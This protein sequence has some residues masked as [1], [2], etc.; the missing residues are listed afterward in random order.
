MVLQVM[1]A[2]SQINT[3]PA[4][5]DQSSIQG[6]KVP[7]TGQAGFTSLSPESLGILLTNALQ[8]SRSFTNQ[9]YLNGSG[10]AVGDV[11]GDGWC[12]LYFCGLDR[13]NALYRNLGNWR[14]EDIT[15]AAGVRG[16]GL[17]STGAVLADIDGDGD[18]DLLV[19]TVGHGTHCFLNDGRGHFQDVTDRIGLGGGAG[20]TSLALA[21]VD[22]DGYLDLFVANYR[23]DTLRDQPNTRFRIK[24]IDGQLTVALVNGRPVSE[25]DLEGRYTVQ[26]EGGIQE[27]GEVSALYLNRSGTHF[28][29]LPFTGGAFSDE[30][31]KPLATAPHDWSLSVLLRDLNGDGL[32]DIYVCND[33]ESP[34]RIWLNRGHGR[35]QAIPRTAI[36]HTS[37]YSMGV[38]V[39]D[40]NR[41]GFDDIFVVD[42]LSRWHDRRIQQSGDPVA[43]R[44][45]ADQVDG[46]P[47]Y[48]MNTLFLNR[49]NGTY[50]EIAGFSGVAASEW[51]WNPTF[52]DV[53]LDGYEDILIT[54]GHERD[55]QNVDV[56]MRVEAVRR[57]G[58][59]TPREILEA[60]R[61]FSRLATANVA[62]R[63][64]GD[65]TFEEVGKAWGFDLVGVSQGMAV[66]DLDND[67][68]LDV[69]I[70]NLNGT[71]TILRNETAAPRL[72]VQLRGRSPN[73]RGIGAKIHVSGGPVTQSQEMISGGRYLSGDQELRVFAAGSREA[74]LTVE[75]DWRSG[76]K[77]RL[78]NV[79]ANSL[80]TVVEP[81]DEATAVTGTNR[82]VPLFSDRSALLNHV[83]VD[84][85]FDD[86]QRQPLLPRRLSQLGPGVAWCDID[87]DGREELVVGSGKG[88]SL[89]EWSLRPDGVWKRLHGAVLDSV[90]N[91]DMVGVVSLPG[92]NGS[93]DL[94]VGMSSYEDSVAEGAGVVLFSSDGM[95][96]RPVS[97]AGDS[98]FGPLAVADIDGDGS[99][100]LFVGGR[101]IPGQYP[102]PA[103]SRLLLRKKD[104]WVADA[105][106]A[107]LLQDIGMIS[108]AVFSD[109]NG[110]GWP[111]LVL[112]TEW[113]PLR[114]LMNQRGHL[115]D[116]T[117]HLGLAALTGGW[118]GVAT[119]D[120]DGD[121]RMD[122]V[123]SNT[124]RNSVARMSEDH[125]RRIY[126]GRGQSGSSV[127]LIESEWDGVN[128][129][130]VPVRDPR[131]LLPALPRL[132]EQFA[133]FASYGAAS[134]DQV[135]GDERTRFRSVEASTGDSLVLLNRGD[136][137]EVHPLPSVAQWTSA[138]AVVVSDWDGDGNQDV[139][140]SQNFFGA[141]PG[142]PRD[143]AGLGLLLLG[144][145]H[146]GFRSVAPLES[147]I[148]INGEQRGAA[149][150]DYD[151]DGR[152]DLVVSQ[153]RGQTRLYH[154]ERAIP[155][156]RVRLNA[157]PDNPTGVGGSVQGIGDHGAGPRLEVQAGSGYWSQNSPIMLLARSPSLR[158]VQVRWPGGATT[159]HELPE[160]IAEL[161]VRPNGDT[162]RI[163]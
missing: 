47:Q 27:N 132:P 42:M 130:E 71:P 14:F 91:R 63:N 88:A 49:G 68:D 75:V 33:F 13:G 38:D 52:L 11:D 79:N 83:H 7:P 148:N 138:F 32:P 50:A 161:E 146:G 98:S 6:L 122:I 8:D 22:G 102:I 142:I 143:D 26:P 86:F 23:R 89:A 67:G 150:G 123:A 55:A 19:N 57:S 65:L 2:L 109:L 95:T 34:D 144:D 135:L 160:G 35:F 24:K 64:R 31:G 39:A 18:L 121:G 131:A 4:A 96:S 43:D 107:H 117:G 149:V 156:I 20:S 145:G 92:R 16:T 48:K 141:R 84:E 36:R 159:V 126:W 120:F 60:R 58:K 114:V 56:G 41:D 158:Q 5:P 90:S 140:L 78:E 53:D 137:F 125:P 104:G 81:L 162:R 28:D 147:G 1:V 99:L 115:S 118:N 85:P 73:T 37:L 66:A 163:Q 74:R 62:F 82:V 110:D 112:A 155:A 9:I 72:A 101:V 3:P 151:S 108:G 133:S 127:D 106:A 10:V 69:I 17:D 77:S 154:N 157:G 105:E 111:D 129:R 59:A 45:L 100:D 119:G 134:L 116:Q 51:S 25:P 113:G 94:V 136:H 128:G 93:S 12:D 76:R 54:N 97:G 152:P 153:N 21:D 30:D 44:V 139:F 124:G 70:N 87:G 40:I 29:V 15:E 46:R 103:S 80:L 61:E